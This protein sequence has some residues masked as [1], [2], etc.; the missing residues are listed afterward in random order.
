MYTAQRSRF[1]TCRRGVAIGALL[2]V[3]GVLLTPIQ[4]YVAYRGLE[5]PKRRRREER[6]RH[7]ADSG[8]VSELRT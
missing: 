2:L 5:R 8:T 4:W 3:V 1:L 7:A 6:R